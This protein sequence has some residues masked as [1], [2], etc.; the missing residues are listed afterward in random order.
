M[1]NG[2]VVVPLVG[3]GSNV[4]VALASGP[5]VPAPCGGETALIVD[6]AVGVGVGVGVG[7][8]VGVGV[9]V[10][11]PV[12]VGVGV[13]P[14]VVA[15]P[16][17]ASPALTTEIIAARRNRSWFRIIAL[18]RTLM[19]LLPGTAYTPLGAG[20]RPASGASSPTFAT[21][22]QSGKRCIPAALRPDAASLI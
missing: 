12:G 14:L 18:T 17:I 4:L 2:N 21:A 20:A 7:V 19:Q 9:G 11:V 13:L 10:A 16:A 1:I 8:D 15:Q 3:L 6:V 22:A 5:A